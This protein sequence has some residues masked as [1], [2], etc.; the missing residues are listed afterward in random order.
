MK[1]ARILMK[2]RFNMISNIEFV[3]FV[4]CIS[5]YV[6][7]IKEKAKMSILM[8]LVKKINLHKTLFNF[9]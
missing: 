4:Y 1:Q 2:L 8:M 3:M 7:I 9:V 6:M 5:I